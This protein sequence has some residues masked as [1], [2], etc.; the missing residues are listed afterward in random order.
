MWPS[1]FRSIQTMSGTPMSTKPKTIPTLT[2]DSIR[3][4]RSTRLLQLVQETVH[5]LRRDVLVVS[6]VHLDHRRGAAGAEAF[7]RDVGEAAVLG[8]L[9]VRDPELLLDLL[10]QLLAAEERAGEVPAD[11]DEVP[12]DR[13]LM[14][15]RVE[16]HDLPDRLRG[17]PEDLPHLALRL[18]AQPAL[19]R[20]RHVERRDERRL[21]GLVDL[22]QR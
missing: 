17:E 7:H 5:R 16:G 3:K 6:V 15:H 14:E 4:A 21:V 11:L 22:C 20:L 9:A 19:V 18:L 8:R 2:N 13:L 10:L 1:T 12:S